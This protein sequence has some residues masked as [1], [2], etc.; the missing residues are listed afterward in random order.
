MKLPNNL[1]L[2]DVMQAAEAQMFDLE[3]TGFCMNCGEPAY[4]VEPDARGYTCEFCEE[5]M[6]YGA[7][8]ILL[9]VVA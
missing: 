3:D 4:Q 6:V 8:E 1:T 5:P 2:D 9:M 7:Q